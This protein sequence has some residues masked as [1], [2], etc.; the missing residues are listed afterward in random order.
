M[1]YLAYVFRKRYLRRKKRT[2]IHGMLENEEYIKT[3]L[4]KLETNLSE[5]S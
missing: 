2:W 3:Q 4:T 5:I 1:F